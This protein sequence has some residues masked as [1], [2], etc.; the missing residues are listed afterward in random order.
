[1]ETVDMGEQLAEILGEKGRP[2]VVI[3]VNR[4]DGTPT[5]TLLASEF[6]I[7]TLNGEDAML[8][9]DGCDEYLLSVADH[10]I[11]RAVKH[12]GESVLH[13]L[14]NCGT[15]DNKATCFSGESADSK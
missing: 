15:C 10:L 7:G 14:F 1:M 13:G 4:G 9:G 12:G 2:K 3:T 5:R 11:R 8:I 6:I